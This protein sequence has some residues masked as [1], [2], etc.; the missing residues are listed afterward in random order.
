MSA[1]NLA[2]RL[3]VAALSALVAGAGAWWYLEHGREEASTIEFVD[4]GSEFRAALEARSDSGE[5]AVSF[6]SPAELGRDFARRLNEDLTHKDLLILFPQLKRKKVNKMQGVHYTLIPDRRWQRKF[7]EHPE[8]RFVRRTNSLGIREDESPS[9][10]PVDQCV[11][12]MGD[13][14][15]EGVC[16]NAETVANQLEARLRGDQPG[17]SVEVWNLAISGYGGA[18]YLGTLTAYGHLEPEDVVLVFYGGNDFRDSLGPWRYIYRIRGGPPVSQEFITPLRNDGNHGTAMLGQ[19]IHQA[20]TFLKYP[21]AGRDAVRLTIACGLEL[22]R[23]CRERGARFLFVYLPPPS[24]GQPE[25]FRAPLEKA[26]VKIKAEPKGL[27]FC[28]ELADDTLAALEEAGVAT[29]DLRPTFA[30]TPEPL[31]WSTELHLNVR[32]HALVADQIHAVFYA[33]TDEPR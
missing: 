10:T 20:L 19:E 18:N 28:R 7:V 13:S 21:E 32:G 17:K 9:E 6:E 33:S 5:E 29:L 16:S 3:G 14:H 31:Y 24:V 22:D 4:D 26:M 8:G 15:A 25:H 1:P 12:V 2:Q 27:D 23:Q 30:A 11:L